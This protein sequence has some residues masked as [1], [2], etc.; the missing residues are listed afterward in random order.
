MVIRVIGE[1]IH[2]PKSRVLRGAKRHVFLKR[3]GSPN[4]NQ[5]TL[6]YQLI[7]RRN[8]VN[9]IACHWYNV[10]HESKVVRGG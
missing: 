1:I 4:H 10:K 5:I 7:I 3:K 6:K 9:P 2:S 8:C